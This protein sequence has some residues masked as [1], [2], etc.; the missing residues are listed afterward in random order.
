MVLKVSRINQ[1]GEC[2]LLVRCTKCMPGWSGFLCGFRGSGELVDGRVGIRVD[3]L[4]G[5]LGG[6]GWVTVAGHSSE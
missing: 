4:R 5:E 3:G 2:I 1:A 6:R